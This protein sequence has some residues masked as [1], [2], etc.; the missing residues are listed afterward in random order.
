MQWIL[1]EKN[2]DLP[3]CARADDRVPFQNLLLGT[4]LSYSQESENF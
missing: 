3:E 4:G 2:V 1:A